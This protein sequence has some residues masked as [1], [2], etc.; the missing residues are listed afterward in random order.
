MSAPTDVF[1]SI[2]SNIGPQQ[3]I[4]AALE[5]LAAQVRIVNVS[6]FYRNSPLDRPGQPEYLNG[7]CEIQTTLPP[8]ELKFECLRNIESAL[9]RVRSEDKH[10]ARTIDLDIALY[11]DLVVQGDDDLV[12]PDPEIYER[13]FL[14]WPLY[15]VAPALVLP[16]TG[17]ALADVVQR[18]D[19]SGLH[20]DEQFTTNVRVRLQL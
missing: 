19:R 12:V 16:D 13:S 14:A 8:R 2:G 7:V 1:I 15:E 5:R 6:T 20:P 9:G 4:P 18:I 3:N 10:A 11:G 17:E